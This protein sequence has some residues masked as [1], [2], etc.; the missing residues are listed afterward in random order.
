MK[1]RTVKV[2]RQ[3][4]MAKSVILEIPEGVTNDDLESC[5]YD[6]CNT[7]GA[8]EMETSIHDMT[9]EEETIEVEDSTEPATEDFRAT[10]DEW[11]EALKDDQLLG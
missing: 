1:T 9:E 3:L 11:I 6:R 5:L 10:D 8:L 2:T 4:T 7:Y